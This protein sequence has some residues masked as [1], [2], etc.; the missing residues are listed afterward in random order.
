MLCAADTA[1]FYGQESAEAVAYH[2][3]QA[4]EG[5]LTDV[6]DIAP[7]VLYLAEKDNWMTG[8]VG[9]VRVR[10]ASC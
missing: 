1:F 10:G 8:Q 6:K 5:R 3:A 9:A 7:L 4:L 2:K